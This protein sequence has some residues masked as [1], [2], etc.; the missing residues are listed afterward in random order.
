MNA[1]ALNMKAKMFAYI[2]L[3]RVHQWVKNLFIFAPAFFAQRF[4]DLNMIGSLILAFLVFSLVAS[5]V[6]ILNDYLDIEK[7]RLHPRK[8][9]RPL[10][11]GTINKNAALL[12]MGVLLTAGIVL[13]FLVNW[14]LLLVIGVYFVM[15]VFYS[16]R[17]KHIAILDISIIAFGFLLRIYAGGVSAEI[18]ISKWIILLT[19]LLAML[20][21]L[22]KRRDEFLLFQQGKETRKSISGYSL[23]FINVSMTLM[24]AVTVVSYIMYTVSTEVV[25]RL[26]NEH[27]YLTTIFVILGIM[28]FL[29]IALVLEESGSPTMVLLKDRFIQLVISAWILT[30]MA[31]LYWPEFR[32]FVVAS[33]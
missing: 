15:N 31:I 19:F 17:L 21:A 25:Q 20:L 22:G 14:R 33:F 32:Q 11:A 4:F 10:A 24:A 2:K 3:I 13:G 1:L 18:P 29:Q 5:S 28:R 30:F 16:F 12:F 7:D 23:P 26:G 6:Y 9:L 27:I 8:R